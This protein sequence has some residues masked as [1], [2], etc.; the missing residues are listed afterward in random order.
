[1]GRFMTPDVFTYAIKTD[2][3]TWNLYSYVANN[4]LNRTDPDGHDWFRIDDKWQWQKGHKFGGPKAKPGSKTHPSADPTSN[5]KSQA[6]AGRGG[7]PSPTVVSRPA[8]RRQQLKRR[9]ELD[10]LVQ[11]AI[12]RAMHGVNPVGALHRRAS[13]FWRHQAHG[14]VDAANDQ[15]A[16]LRFHFSGYICRQ[17]SVAGIDLARFQRTS[18]C[19]QHSA[20]G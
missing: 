6:S 15:N 14:H 10:G 3:Q 20:L 5:L 11:S 2:P 19:P 4:P 8:G 1:M 9:S 13:L 18:K 7:T 12:E 17:L 16:F